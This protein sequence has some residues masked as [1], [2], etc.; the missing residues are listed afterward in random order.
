MLAT[1][2]SSDPELKSLMKEVATGNATQ[3]QLKVFQGHIDELT[4]VINEKKKSE[5]EF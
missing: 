5:G 3:E 4:K 1:R 2:A